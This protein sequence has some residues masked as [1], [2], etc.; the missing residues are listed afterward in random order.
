MLRFQVLITG[1]GNSLSE[2][3]RLAASFEA[4]LTQ[5]SQLDRLFIEPDGSFVWRGSDSGGSDWQVDGS[6][7]DQGEALAYVELKGS[8][9]EEQLDELLRSLGWPQHQLA[10]QLPRRG[11]V[12]SESEFRGL[13][14]TIEGAI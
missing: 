7:V 10:F 1:T 4:T 5:L 8:C 9:P 11:V 2:G 3:S 6:L 13:A 14:A 12:L